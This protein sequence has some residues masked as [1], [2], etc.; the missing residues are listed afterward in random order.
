MNFL[1]FGRVLRW[2]A[3]LR[4]Q[5]TYQIRYKY[6]NICRDNYIGNYIDT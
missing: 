2:L 3:Y 4:G 6:T 5:V 1:I